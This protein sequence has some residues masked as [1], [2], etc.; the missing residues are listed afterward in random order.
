MSELDHEMGFPSSHGAGS[1]NLVTG[2][3]QWWQRWH[4]Y[5]LT[6]KKGML[7]Y[8]LYCLKKSVFSLR[9]F[10]KAVCGVNKEMLQLSQP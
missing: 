5:V 2:K 8:A 4:L 9:Y 1:S 6:F 3:S 7:L 10:Y